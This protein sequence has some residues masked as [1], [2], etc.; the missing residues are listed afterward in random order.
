M[1][2]EKH[3]GAAD[4]HGPQPLVKGYVLVYPFAYWSNASTF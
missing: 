3:T 4:F 2:S 1:P